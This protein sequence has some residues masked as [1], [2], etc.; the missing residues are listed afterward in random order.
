MCY[1]LTCI[2]LIIIITIHS[3]QIHFLS[4]VRI[5]LLG[6]VLSGKSSAKNIILNQ[7]EQGLQSS[8]DQ[9]RKETGSVYDRRVTVVDTPGWWKY[10]SAQYTPEWVKTELAQAVTLGSKAP[11]ALLLVVPADVS[12]LEEQRQIIEENM[13]MCF[14][15]MAWKHTLV[16][17]SW[18]DSLGNMSIEEHIENEGEPLTWLVEK[19]G[20]RYHVFNKLN[21]GDSSQVYQLLEKIDEMDA[22]T[23]SCGLNHKSAEAE[24]TQSIRQREE[25]RPE[26]LE[27]LEKEWSRRDKEL[28]ENIKTMWQETFSSV[29]SNNSVSRILDCEYQLH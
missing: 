10:F 25:V 2:I 21:S 22:S 1:V 9:C 17:F 11:H 23:S 29:K 14:G 7:I 8:T 13:R 20:N 3:G 24:S 12:F 27:Y 26:M 15:E 16:L 19:C 6:W 4:E 28:E 18:G 5:V